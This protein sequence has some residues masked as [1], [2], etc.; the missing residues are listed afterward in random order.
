MKRLKFGSQPRAT[1]SI[2]YKHNN[3]AATVRYND[4]RDIQKGNKLKLCKQNGEVFGQACV[5]DTIECP[6]YAAYPEIRKLGVEY[7]SAGTDYMMSTLN[8][9]YDDTIWP[10]TEVKIIIYRVVQMH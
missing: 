4:E 6:A 7:P 5:V 8:H 3:L 1:A 2:A 9:H 10:D